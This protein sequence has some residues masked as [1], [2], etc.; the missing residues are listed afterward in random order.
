M[1][2]YDSALVGTNQP[3]PFFKAIKYDSISKFKSST[4]ILFCHTYIHF[5][6]RSPVLANEHKHNRRFKLG[7]SMQIKNSYFP[8]VKLISPLN[9]FMQNLLV[10]FNSKL[11]KRKIAS[12][13]LPPLSNTSMF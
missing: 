6:E 5:K 7:L 12:R 9:L 2:I 11:T 1:N 3:E 8:I 10:R 13:N 4:I